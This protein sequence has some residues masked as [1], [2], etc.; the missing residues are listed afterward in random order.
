MGDFIFLDSSFFKALV[1]PKDD[2]H[3]SAENIF[4]SLRQ[5]K[6][7]LTTSNYIL[8]ETFTLIRGRCGRKYL[9]EFR[10]FLAESGNM[11]KIYRVT[12]SDEANAWNWILEDWSNLSF[13]DCVSF[14]MM[15]R[16]EIK[17][18]ATFDNHFTR[19]GFKIED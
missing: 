13:T 5:E 12:V 17:R 7:I 16:L 8:D 9:K 4:D 15:E 3:N 14:A 10:D 19:A 1:D 6:A 2:F 18:V 11:I